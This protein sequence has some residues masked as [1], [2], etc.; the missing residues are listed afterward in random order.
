VAAQQ[1]AP[2]E[3]TAIRTQQTHQLMK[4]LW[5]AACRDNQNSLSLFPDRRII[6]M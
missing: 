5:L 4:K 3:A 1:E 6:L 2:G